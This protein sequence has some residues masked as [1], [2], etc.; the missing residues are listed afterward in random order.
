M[1]NDTTQTATGR[2]LFAMPMYTDPALQERWR[3]VRVRARIEQEL[4]E[5][6]MRQILDDLTHG[7]IRLSDLMRKCIGGHLR[8]LN[9]PEP[10]A[11]CVAY[12]RIVT[13][14]F[15]AARPEEQTRRF[16]GVCLSAQDHYEQY[17]N[18]FRT[19]CRDH[20]VYTQLISG[21]WLAYRADDLTEVHDVEATETLENLLNEDDALR[22]ASRN[23]RA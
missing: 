13:D 7:G 18:A 20:L 15:V 14:R 12:D 11:D 21:H 8:S 23:G 22:A 6:F 3:R 5:Q 2:A 19:L 16:K 1:S 17:L 4:R 9:Q 10:A